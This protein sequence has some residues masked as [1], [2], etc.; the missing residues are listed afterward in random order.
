MDIRT[1]RGIVVYFAAAATAACGASS[2]RTTDQATGSSTSAV[3][4]ESDCPGAS[5]NC[6]ILPR[7]SA[8]PTLS[9]S[10]VPSNGDV[11]PYG[12]AFV[13]AGFPAGG[14]LRPGDVVVA[15]FN[16]A[17]N[18][19]GTG[20]TIARVNPNAAPSLFFA[21][22]SAPGFS[23]ALGILQRGFVLVGNLP[24]TD[25]SGVCTQVGD[26]ET[27][28]GRGALLVINRQGN[29]VRALT[30]TRFLDGPWDLA[31]DDSGAEAKVFVT[32]ALSGSVT[33]LDLRVDDD[34]VAVE[35]ETVIASGYVHRCDPAAFV[36]GPTGLALDRVR[37][38]LY[39]ASAGDNA[40]FAVEGASQATADRGPGT[41]AVSDSVHLHGP[42]GLV[43]AANGDLISAQGDAVNADTNHP[44]EIVE[45]APTGKFVTEFSIDSTPGSAFGLALEQ[46]GDHFRFAAVDDGLNV[47]DEWL[48]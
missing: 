33:R 26:E 9:A 5:S 19:Q 39:V 13:P 1:A 16:N 36:V 47:L 2:D 46:R 27:G 29:L 18:L 17:A 15:N 32:N 25:G 4:A 44:S 48:R 21:D 45:F 30:S 23:T 34:D 11:N 37:D 8:A 7:L 42:L 35:G 24:S 43:R 38:V 31:I 12:I 22:A 20:T 3:T 41:V 10:T 6:G 28:A 40:I 14:I